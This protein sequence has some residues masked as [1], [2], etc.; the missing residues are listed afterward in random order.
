MISI[1]C[2]LHAWSWY[3]AVN[4]KRVEKFKSYFEEVVLPFPLLGLTNLLLVFMYRRL[5]RFYPPLTR[6]YPPIISSISKEFALLCFG[7]Q[8]FN[9]L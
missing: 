9:S 1:E 2:M 5:T 8:T 4:W 7:I 3:M 6:F